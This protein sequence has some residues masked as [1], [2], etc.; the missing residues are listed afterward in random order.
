MTTT[1][2][3]KGNG[4]ETFEGPDGAELHVIKGC[5]LPLTP[6]HLHCP[7]QDRRDALCVPASERM[8]GRGTVKYDAADGPA[9]RASSS[10]IINLPFFS[11]CSSSCTHAH[12][13]LFCYPAR[14]L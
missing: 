11:L 8:R 9:D 13:S 3:R 1:T 6:L 7:S 12:F 4:G 5:L 2:K 14:Y 10:L